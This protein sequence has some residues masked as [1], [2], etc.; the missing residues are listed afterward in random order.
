MNRIFAGTLVAL[1]LCVSSLGVACDLSCG[2]PTDGSNCHTQ[3][4]QTH[5][6][7]LPNMKMG[8]MAGT[9]M[10]EMDDASS[11]H[12]EVISN[13]SHAMA[14]HAALIDMNACERQSCNQEQTA[15][16]SNRSAV[17]NF[18]TTSPVAGFFQLN[19][20]E[21]IFHA[22]WDGVALHHFEIHSPLNISL[23]I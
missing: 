8:D 15:A 22:T 12:Q 9:A 14:A 1:M 23:R 4:A 2:F 20:R 17:R 6:S 16:Q 21:A 13:S 5:D 3:Q 19:N 11:P 10:P 7:A 18:D